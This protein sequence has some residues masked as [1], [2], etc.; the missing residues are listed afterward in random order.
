M[1]E[2]EAVDTVEAR[3]GRPR[4]ERIDRAVLDAIGQMILEGGYRSLSFEGVAA[5]S[6]VTKN[7]VYRRYPTK[8]D[9][10]LA[11]LDRT[12][13]RL[14]EPDAN[15]SVDDNVQEMLRQMVRE[16]DRDP[17]LIGVISSLAGEEQGDPQLRS[18]VNRYSTERLQPLFEAL[19]LGVERG[20]LP[21][22]TD[23]E[24]GATLLY[25]P[26]LAEYM[27]HGPVALH[28]VE[29][30]VTTVLSGLRH[31]PPGPSEAGAGAG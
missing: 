15:A 10:A 14:P 3:R 19:R 29:R 20:E 22:S 25:G 5:R 13:P 8:A 28:R 7:T 1:S 17:T 16:F 31:L 9:L 26:V 23:V 18:A 12:H 21:D 24:I 30:M 27:L 6:S 2:T 11:F 4:D